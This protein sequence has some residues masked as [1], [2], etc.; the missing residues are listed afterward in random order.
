MSKKSISFTNKKIFYG[1][2]GNLRGEWLKK[3]DPGLFNDLVNNDEL[4]KYLESY[5]KSYAIKAHR[6]FTKL[7]EEN[8]V[9]EDLYNND[10]LTYMGLQYKISQQ[11]KQILKKEIEQ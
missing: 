1:Y 5:Q 2:Y 7:E 10:Y 8:N 11:V 6:L 4:D 3:N 9:N